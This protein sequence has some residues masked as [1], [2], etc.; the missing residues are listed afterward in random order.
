MPLVLAIQSRSHPYTVEGFPDL[1]E[2]VG[3]VSHPERAHFLVDWNLL[4]L[5]PAE[6]APVLLE[7]RAVILDATEEQKSYEAIAPVFLRLIEKGLKRDGCLVVIG[8]GVMQDI[9]CFVATNL[10]R[11]IPWEF[12]PTTLLS[13]AD[14]CIGSKSSV[15]IGPFKNQIGSFYAPHRVLM[16]HSVLGTLPWDQIRS[17]VGEIL[18]LALLTGQAETEELTAD[19][20]VFSGET[21]VIQKWVPRALGIKKAYIEEDE[22]D[23]GRRNLLNYGHT[24]GHAF[25]STTHFGIPHGIAVTLGILAA[26]YTSARLGMVTPGHYLDIKGKLIPW[27]APYGQQLAQV[28]VEAILHA[29]RHDKKNSSSGV[30][31]ILTRGFGAMGKHSLDAETELKPILSA[32]LSSELADLSEPHTHSRSPR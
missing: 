26:T 17:G 19:L 15:N 10:A 5:Y 1:G 27:S 29:M 2:A 12:I 8:G 32:F 28:D 7:G 31:C 6:L 14:S 22:F 4:E 3:A 24:F 21:E 9:G 18:K 11:G 23:R 30:T 16:T 20:S 13:Q 25:E